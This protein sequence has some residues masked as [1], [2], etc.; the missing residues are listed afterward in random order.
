MAADWSSLMEGCKRRKLQVQTA[1][2]V[3]CQEAAIPT[4]RHNAFC[5][6]GLLAAISAVRASPV[7]ADAALLPA[8]WVPFLLLPRLSGLLDAHQ[9][10]QSPNASPADQHGSY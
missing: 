2:T 1:V 6:T 7:M 3:G 8:V 9:S 4:H 10:L 5:T